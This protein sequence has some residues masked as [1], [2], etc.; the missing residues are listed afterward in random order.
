MPFA[1]TS[2][3][4]ISLF[5]L[6]GLRDA[7]AD[8]MLGSSCPGCHA[9]GW[10][11]CESCRELLPSNPHRLIRPGWQPASQRPDQVSM[12]PAI[13]T[14]W[15]R[16]PLSSIIIAHKDDGAWQLAH[17]LGGL[18]A[19]S[20]AGLVPQ[21]RTGLKEQRARSPGVVLVP[22][23]SD[24]VAVRRRGYDH[25]RALASAAGRRLG[26]SVVPLLIRSR[27]AHD[28]VGRGRD[29]RLASQSGTMLA[30]NASSRPVIVTDDLVTTGAT[31]VEAV[32][33]LRAAGCQVQG[34]AVI[35]DTPKHATGGLRSADHP[36][37]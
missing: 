4:P 27:T 21:D 37:E 20:I 30:L 15:Y 26:L 34:I 29:A 11:L 28:Q 9:P 6:R 19:L 24:Q 25:S 22:V 35:G 18:L 7:A 1:N 17:Q 10:G 3:V 33:A 31:I 14:G 8:L 23:P 36:D 12:P 13:A 2:G 5:N 32:R 16:E